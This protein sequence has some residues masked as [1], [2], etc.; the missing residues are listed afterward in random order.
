[1]AHK[2]NFRSLDG[3]LWVPEYIFKC[4]LSEKVP[5]MSVNVRGNTNVTRMHM[6]HNLQYNDVCVY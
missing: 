5:L 4:S 1:M 2:T 6:K 3:W